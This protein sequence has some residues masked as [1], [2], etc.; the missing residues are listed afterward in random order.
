MS[1]NKYRISYAEDGT[2]EITMPARGAGTHQPASAVGQHGQGVANAYPSRE[3]FRLPAI[4]N[5]GLSIVFA[6][7]IFFSV[8]RFAPHDFRPSTL[9]GGYEA[10]IDM[11]LK[12]AELN[13]QARFENY[14][15]EL[16]IATEN[17]NKE[18]EKLLESV[19]AHYAEVY[20]RG[21]II[22]QAATDIQGRY[23]AARMAQAEATQSADVGV[24]N[25]AVLVA[26]G[27]NLY[28]PGMGDDALAYAETRRKELADALTKAA[29][30][31][32][33]IDV[34]GW[35]AGLPS[36]E[37]VARELNSVPLMKIPEAPPL[38]RHHNAIEGRQQGDAPG[39]D[40]P[41]NGER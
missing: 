33:S 41:A 36:P 5:T 4:V 37:E 26:R 38:A 40:A 3:P 18:V 24:T 39:R 30:D 21:R 34:T 35:D 31:G 19:L 32:A 29:Q 10:S 25:L 23:V 22:A 7:V 15:A 16:R 14:M 28:Q 2:A 1:E 11:Q 12:A 13:E 6:G 27:L 9:V 8:E 20:A 17:H